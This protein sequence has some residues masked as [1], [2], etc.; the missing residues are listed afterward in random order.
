[1]LLHQVMALGRGACPGNKHPSPPR[2][3]AYFGNQQSMGPNGA[4][5]MQY[6]VRVTFTTVHKLRNKGRVRGRGGVG[7]GAKDGRG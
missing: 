3:A 4:R 2:A 5:L 6:Y 7:R 1:M